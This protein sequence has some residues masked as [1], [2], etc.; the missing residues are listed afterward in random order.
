MYAVPRMRLR[1]FSVCRAT[2][3]LSVGLLFFNEELV[4]LRPC[5]FQ[6]LVRNFSLQL[7][8]RRF[9]FESTSSGARVGIRMGV[10]VSGCAGVWVCW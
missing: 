2:F 5:L 6:H 4:F 8:F 10:R 1:S 3:V 7:L 9:N